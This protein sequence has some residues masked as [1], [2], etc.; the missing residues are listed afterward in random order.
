M[1]FESELVLRLDRSEVKRFFIFRL[2]IANGNN[3][4]T[5]HNCFLSNVWS[6]YI[7]LPMVY[8][9]A[10]CVIPGANPAQVTAYHYTKVQFSNSFIYPPSCTSSPVLPS[11]C[12]VSIDL[13]SCFQVKG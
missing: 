2:L 4:T 6:I 7:A 12:S 13:M 3:P 5:F 9:C 8:W 1:W 10:W 11:T